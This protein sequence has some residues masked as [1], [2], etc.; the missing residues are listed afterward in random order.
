MLA[1]LSCTRSAPGL[2]AAVLALSIGATPAAAQTPRTGDGGNAAAEGAVGKD[3]NQYRSRSVILT[4][5]L[6]EEKA[7]ALLI[8]LETM[9]DLVGKFFGAPLRKPIP[10]L[11]WKDTAKWQGVPLPPEAQAKMREGGGITLGQTMG[12][13]NVYTGQTRRTDSMATA[14]A[15]SKRGTPLHE[16]VHAYCMLTFGA[17]G[18]VW[19]GEGLAELGSYFRKG[20]MSVR[21]SRG[22]MQ[23]LQTAERQTLRE[24]LDPNAITGDSWENYAWRWALA[25]VLAYNPNYRDRYRPL[26][27]SLMNDGPLTFESVY[28]S[29]APE[30]TFEYNFFLD[31]LE[32]GVRPDLIAWDWKGRYRA[33]RKGRRATARLQADAGWQPGAIEVKEGTVVG[34]EADGEWSVGPDKPRPT[35]VT[36]LDDDYEPPVE[37]ETAATEPPPPVSADGGEDGRGK[38]VGAIFDPVEYTLSDEFELGA[39][40]EFTAPSAGQLVLRAK[41][42][43]GQLG[44]NEGRMTVKLVGV[45]D[46]PED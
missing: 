9:L 34:Y 7:E 36:V 45:K 6:D 15:S 12:L 23:H 39:S 1:R 41:D 30:I 44:D 19:F 18:P 14:Y 24:I 2:L 3:L 46:A 13:T 17:T 25:H 10:L 4:T 11:V 20:D 42:K 43:W 33:I 40:G 38:L 28:G 32:Q 16:S 8:E 5:D 22:V 21:V 26:G 29:M 31:V 35:H 37:D 27:V